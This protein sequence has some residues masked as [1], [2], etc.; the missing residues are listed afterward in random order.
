MRRFV[1][2]GYLLFAVIGCTLVIST[3]R[4]V[5]QAPSA[6]Q[7]IW[8]P[9]A[10]KA[11]DTPAGTR[12]F[13]KVFTVNRPVEKVADEAEL[14]ITA[15]DA[16]TVWV[17]GKEVGS[18]QNW[19]QMFRFDVAP[20]IVNGK[21][22]IAVKATAKAGRAGF[23]ARL[24][25]VP[26]GQPR[27]AIATDTS[28][29]FANAAGKDWE[30]PS[31][32]D[33]GWKYAHAIGAYGQV[34]AW[35]D[36][37]W[38]KGGNDRF[39]VP[40]GF[41][42]EQAAINPKPGDPFSL[43]N[44]TFDS[45]GRLLVS[46]ERG[47]I[48][49]CTEPNKDGA[50]AKVVPYCSVVKNCQGMCW[51]KDALLVVGEGPQGV[52]LYRVR[53][54]GGNDKAEDAQ[55][56]HKVKGSIGDHGPHAILHGPD[57]WLY[58]VLGNH[59][60]AQPEKL[61]D[62]S[63]LRRWP[64]G[65]MGPDQN[66]PHTTEDVLLPRLNDARG[67]AA[68]ILAP[69][70]TIWRLDHE[71]KNMSLVAAGFRNHFDASF[72]PLG[73]LFTFDSDMEWD[74]NLPWYRPVRACHCPP[75]ADFVWRTGSANTPAYYVDSLPSV[76]DTGRGS[77]VGVEFYDHEAFPAPYRG[78]FFM[79]DWSLG[80]IYALFPERVGA[81]YRGRV[82]RFCTGA[83]LNVT[84][85]AV[86]PDGAL[87]FTMGGRNSQG[88]VY[89][90]V[91]G[92]GT[93]PSSLEHQP[94]SAWSRARFEKEIRDKGQ[95]E[96][97]TRYR[98][99]AQEPAG[100]E[101]IPNR[102]RALDR[103]QGYL[104]RP[105]AGFLAKLL[106]DPQPEIRA[107]AI[108][109]MGVN[110]YTECRAKLTECL[111]D[112]DALVRRHACEA[113]IRAGIEAP[114]D[115]IWPLL[116]EPDR[117][118]RT[119][120]RLNLE[121]TPPERWLDR[122]E[123]ET[124]AGVF[125]EGIIALAKTDQF[126]AYADRLYPRLCDLAPAS[127]V[128]A[129]LDHL[130]TLQMALVHTSHVPAAA[131]RQAEYCWRLFPHADAN[132]NRELAI[133]LTH[134]KRARLCDYPVHGKLLQALGESAGNRQQQ[135]HYFYCLR[136]LH[137][138]WSA[139][140]KRALLD[141]YQA[142][143][144][145]TGGASFT[146]FLENILIGAAPTFAAADRQA[147]LARALEKPWAATAVLRMAGDGLLPPPAEL[148]DLYAKVRKKNDLAK[149][150]ELEEAILEALGRIDTP[151]AAAALLR[152]GNID[153]SRR[154]AVVRSL[155]KS[156]RPEGWA[157]LVRGLDSSQKTVILEAVRALKKLPNTPKTDDPGPYRTLLLASK[158]LD[159]RNRWTVVELLRHW[160]KDKRFGADDGD[161][162]AELSAWSRWFQQTFPKEPKL[163]DVGSD[164]PTESQYKFPEL[165]AYLEKDPRGKQGD[166]ARGR[167]VFEKAQCMK[168]HKYGKDGEGI[169]PD[170]TTLSKRFKRTDT[171]ES[172]LFPSKVISDQYR[173]TMIMT[174]S[175]Q[176]IIGLAAPQG[177]AIT[178]LQSD[179]TKVSLKKSEIDQQ[180]ASLVSVMPEKL[181]DPLTKEEIAD[182]FAYLESEPK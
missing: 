178:V 84:D 18:G 60:W 170:L 86:G 157:F 144:T 88:G 133:L 126:D 22:V 100:K 115:A 180:F 56:L 79:G 143:S 116:A 66:K 85:M 19:K 54:R 128:P 132:V 23:L 125:R 135:I 62:N 166:A 7:W 89:R 87:Y 136:L 175:G 42:V 69:G 15:D 90:I 6:V 25:Y 160:T 39:T 61:A 32:D 154:D 40:E 76:A 131:S 110:G 16:F 20:L 9:E 28:W 148:S 179:G 64:T 71:G 165:L 12:Y 121:R 127:G 155:A 45:R 96:L 106:A 58:F 24:S 75:G 47:P 36:L 81:S 53:E 145:W 13:R 74:E 83:P 171:L 78:A 105:E 156:P 112:P 37:A 172:I 176:Q 91:Y 161:W 38:S 158:Q 97:N 70:G 120:A 51:V 2:L 27:R 29:K 159:A 31:F 59:T 63:P 4:I 65:Q 102:I 57:G 103:L 93:V 11:K 147:A 142:T 82:E 98:K 153:D 3:Q 26:N 5:A 111:R 108:W 119:A 50:F 140:E 122:L 124:H 49:L 109:L 17:N 123:K 174:K 169:G 152:I 117:F 163:A 137:D 48:L 149:R 41:R 150:T 99:I 146:Q 34:P 130:R 94:L 113:L 95:A 104:Q 1:L 129:I 134:F 167:I 164:K 67:H 80:I 182:L 72:S 33:A 107:H 35:K 141:W 177:E 138:G 44:M 181:L 43:V 101:G 151:E 21:N 162:K 55:L 30:K 10:E 168:C 68:N 14:A 139:Q 8:T 73:E 114:V 52:G 77:P 92:K 118:L 173:S 46:Q